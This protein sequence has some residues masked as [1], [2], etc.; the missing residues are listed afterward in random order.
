MAGGR[1]SAGT[2]AERGAGAGAWVAEQTGRLLDA[3][4]STPAMY[5][6]DV[7]TVAELYEVSSIHDDYADRLAH[8]P[9]TDAYLAA[10]G[11]WL[12]RAVSAAL[13]R[14]RKLVVLDCDN[15]LWSGICGEQ[16]PENVIVSEPYLRLQRF[17][18]EQRAKGKLLALCSRN[19]EAD[20]LA[21]FARA[22]M[23]LP[24]EEI[25]ARRIG[26]GSKAAAIGELA[27]ELGFALDAVVFVDDDPVECALVADEL[28]DVAV[29]GVPEEP[30]DIPAALAHEWAFDQL[31]VTD[32]DRFR[33]DRYVQESRRREARDTAADY[34]AFLK[35]CR[36]EIDLVPLDEAAV[37]R[38]AQLTV[39]TSQF[40]LTSEAFTPAGLRA[41]LAEGDGWT[42]RVRDRFGDYGTV[43]VV[44]TGPASDDVLG[45]RLLLLSCRV[46][47]RGVDAEIVRFLRRRAA[48]LDCSSLRLP[49]RKTAR[50][51][52]ARLFLEQLAGVAIP[53]EEASLVV[54]VAVSPA[55]QAH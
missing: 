24:L 22:D 18:R 36:T 7:R 21:V 26:W 38:A 8:L 27:A 41:F 45:V 1:A 16:G 13:S 10:L 32:D 44:L 49:Y 11:T 46:L 17:M 53:G 19:D 33:A 25:A 20:V 39:R 35:R 31:V 55:G 9:Y 29:F 14:P 43:G 51:L 30:G 37:E 4:R 28:A 54:P 40:N 48:E 6:V 23:E 3:V 2:V 50:N 5:E 34:A 12:A 42:V 15:T 52:P 47:N